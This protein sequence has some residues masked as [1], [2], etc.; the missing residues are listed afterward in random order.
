[1]AF[2]NLWSEL[3]GHVPELDSLLAQTLINRAWKDIREARQWSWLRGFGV[4]VAPQNITTGT[5]SVTQF[6]KTVTLD[7]AAN[8]ALNNLNNPLITQRQFRVS[9]G[10]IYNIAGYSNGSSTLTL[11]R[12]YM[13][14]NLT[15]APY[16]CYRCYYQPVDSSGNLVSDFLL[17]K[18]IINP[19]DGYAIV[20]EN[21]RL[22][23]QEIDARDPTRGSQDVMYTLAN[24][25][26][27]SNGVPIFEAW[28][29]PTSARAYLC[30]Y[31]KR[32]AELSSSV[33]LPVTLSSHMVIEHAM[34]YVCDWA[35]ENT[36]R[37]PSLKGVDWRLLK[38]E[39]SR[40][41]KTMLND[42]MRN[43]DNLL[44]DN[45]LPQL[46]DYLN[47]PPIDSAFMQRHDLG[48]WGS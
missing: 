29:H 42:A 1:M 25:S 2:A 46:R 38:A 7:S 30:L 6:S 41:Y 8:A 44:L 11:D 3:L 19:I 10:P 32:G 14:Q 9:Q 43:D 39:H 37:Y 34:D 26:V 27:D 24:F 31:I 15:G 23:R 33:D 4:M 22:T 20:G 17:F 21:L 36:G 13:E 35:M 12:P 5:V 18:S 28:P 48:L 40:K 45:F 16:A 47:Y